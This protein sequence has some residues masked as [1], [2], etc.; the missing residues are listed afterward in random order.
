MLI[1]AQEK[2]VNQELVSEADFNN[3]GQNPIENS[4]AVRRSRGRKKNKEGTDTKKRKRAPAIWEKNIRKGL[5]VHGKQYYTNKGKT[6]PERKLK[7]PCNCRKKCY[8]IFSPAYRQEIFQSFYNLSLE[9]QNQFL[10]GFVEEQCKKVKRKKQIIRK[11]E[12][13]TLENTIFLII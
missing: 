10:A 2:T 12:E 5:K 1:I 8:E 4:I 13:N 7:D 9:A 3:A 11:A 6:I